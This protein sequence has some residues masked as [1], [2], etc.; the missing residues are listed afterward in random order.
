GYYTASPGGESLIGWH[1]NRAWEETPD[2]FPV[3]RFR[4][5]FYRPDVVLQALAM[6]DEDKAIAEADRL[7]AAERQERDIRRLLPPVLEILSPKDGAPFHSPN[8]PIQYAARS[9]T[10]ERV[11]DIELYVDGERIRTRGFVPVAGAAPDAL[12]LSLPRRNVKVTLVARSG[13]RTSVPR[14]ISLTWAG[15]ATEAKPKP[16]L[17]ALLIGVSDYGNPGLIKLQYA[18][19]DARNLAATLRGQEGKAF[20]KV[21]L[22]LLINADID[23]IK[24]GLT[25]LEDTVQEGDL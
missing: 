19:E 5:R 1:V 20:L 13:E 8:V 12:E 10:G 17:R 16:R 6:L 23:E 22:K 18:H 2:F 25:W 11:T 24:D 7:A 9:P 21:D 14:S 4:D 3:N 15:S